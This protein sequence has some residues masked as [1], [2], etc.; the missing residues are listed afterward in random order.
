MKILIAEDDFTTRT[1]LASLLRKFGHDVIETANGAEALK[2][3]Q[4]PDAPRLAILDWLMPEIDG[5]EVCRQIRSLPTE[6]PTY[7]IILT[8]KEEKTDLITAL[9][10]GADDFLSKPPDPG[11]LNSRIN[12]GRRMLELQGKLTAKISELQKALDHIN[13]LQGILPICCFCKKIRDDLGYWNKVENY[14][15]SHTEVQFSHSICPDCMKK[16]YP[17]YSDDTNPESTDKNAGV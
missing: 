2:A 11:E 13:I 4:L 12:V 15:S 6:Q 14:I 5:V 7:L 17:D 9:D 3:M 1:V 10:A 8:S 16:H